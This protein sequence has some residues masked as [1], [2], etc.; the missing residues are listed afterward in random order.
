MDSRRARVHAASDQVSAWRDQA[1]RWLL[2]LEGPGRSSRQGQ[3]PESAAPG[4]LVGEL[5]EGIRLDP[6]RQWSQSR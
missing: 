1:G 4:S 5:T 2:S 3:Q 6:A